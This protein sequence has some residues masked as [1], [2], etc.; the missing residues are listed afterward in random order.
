MTSYVLTFAACLVV[1][2]AGRHH[3][4]DEGEYGKDNEWRKLICEKQSDDLY[5]DMDG[6][7][8]LETQLIRDAVS[9]CIKKIMPESSASLIEFASTAC[10]DKPLFIKFDECFEENE[11]DE[12]FEKQQEISPEVKACYVEVLNK[13][14]L[15]EL[16]HYLEES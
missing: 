8:Q 12:E 1:V 3:E 4:G 6:C 9:G 7:F 2:T 5:Q 13:H 11:S 10:E 14:D 15:K 16:L